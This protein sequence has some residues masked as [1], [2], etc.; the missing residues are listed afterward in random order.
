MPQVVGLSRLSHEETTEAAMRLLWEW[1]E[2]YGIPKALYTDR[3]NVYVTAFF[4][5]GS[6]PVHLR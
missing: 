1:I 5:V 4:D 3:K 6:R 2:L